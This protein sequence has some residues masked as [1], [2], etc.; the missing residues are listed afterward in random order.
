MVYE[1]AESTP[2]S[3]GFLYIAATT[4]ALLISSQRIIAFLGALVLIGL[5]VAY[6]AYWEAFVSVWC[7][8]AAAASLVVL[9]HFETLRRG[10]LATAG[11]RT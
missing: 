4:F 9:G 2:I 5:L 3:L 6:N 8:F 7:F 1:S 10:R 11:T